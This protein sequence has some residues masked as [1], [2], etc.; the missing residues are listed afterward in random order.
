MHHGKIFG[1]LAVLALAAACSGSTDSSSGSSGSSG[2]GGSGGSG[3]TG[4]PGLCVTG[5]V[6]E[7]CS[8]GGTV[9]AEGYCCSGVA[10]GTACSGAHCGDG[11]CG[12]GETGINCSLDCPLPAGAIIADHHAVAAFDRIPEEALQAA[13]ALTLHYGHTSHGS[14]IVSGLAPLERQDPTGHAYET[15][16]GGLPASAGALRIHDLSSVDPAGYWDG[17]DGVAATTAVAATGDYDLS[18]WSWCGEQASNDTATVQRY[19]DTVAGFERHFPQMRFIL[20]TGHSDP[21]NAETLAANNELVRTYAAEHGMVLFDF[22]DIER[23]DPAGNHYPDTTDGCDWCPA[24]CAA[25]PADCADL[26]SSCA[27]S[28]AAP[29]N[30]YNCVVKAKAFWWMMARLA[31]W[32]GN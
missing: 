28:D 16:S 24:W 23:W 3:G 29:A 19:L 4:T 17:D 5:L 20:M 21:Y 12:A 1:A 22:A 13:R 8:C 10:Q 11:S 32:D 31:G 2:A 25:H 26:P 7:R 18:M 14:Q 9:V 27:H 30:R 6:S 15:S